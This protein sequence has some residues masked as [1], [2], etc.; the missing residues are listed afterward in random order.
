MKAFFYILL[1][2]GLTSAYS[3][4]NCKNFRTGKF[5]NIENGILKAEIQRN[6]TIQTEKYGQKE[7]KLKIEWINDCS[8]LLKFLEG[9]T[10]FWNSRPKNKPTPDLIVRIT[11]TEGNS[12]LQ[13]SKFDIEDAF[14]YK[15]KIT[16]IE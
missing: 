1:V 12:Y 13:E 8:Y 5:Q 11:G 16:K 15:S 10:A 4:E 3:Q 2:L 9:N 7:V 14:I 6:D